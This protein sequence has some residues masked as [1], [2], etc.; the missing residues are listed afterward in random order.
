MRFLR[1][2]C[3][4][5]AIG[6]A[7]CRD[8]S[9]KS[10]VEK[11]Q[12]HWHAVD[13][14]SVFG[15]RYILYTLDVVD[16]VMEVNRYSMASYPVSF[17][18]YDSA[19]GKIQLPI[20]CLNLQAA[21][22]AF[23]VSADSLII[24]DE[25]LLEI[26]ADQMPLAFVRANSDACAVTHALEAPQSEIQI[27]SVPTSAVP[28]VSVQKLYEKYPVTFLIVGTPAKPQYYGT[29]PRIL[30]DD[31]FIEITDL[32]R[33]FER[34]RDR[35]MDRPFAICLILSDELQDQYVSEFIKATRESHH[36][37]I[38]QLFDFEGTLGYHL[39]P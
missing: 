4:V 22:V 16:S 12:G 7:G 24:H 14:D 18:L 19:S 35:W 31:V 5:L 6:F 8:N 20:H 2:A 10:T 25:K 26:C 33:Y 11:L 17:S 9:Q 29:A 34:E 32:S 28:G 15:A 21:V 30:A 1:F 37:P 27:S 23:E 13:P 39:L 3:L 38:Y 36:G